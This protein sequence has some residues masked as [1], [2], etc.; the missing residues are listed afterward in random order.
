[1]ST[2]LVTGADRGLGLGI[3]KDL[4]G[5][6]WRVFAGQYLPDWPQLSELRDR[7]AGSLSIVP[8]DVSSV[9]SCREAAAASCVQEKVGEPNRHGSKATYS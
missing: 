4:L 9:A 6:G 2:A 1:M 8:L 3:T 5:R 7:H